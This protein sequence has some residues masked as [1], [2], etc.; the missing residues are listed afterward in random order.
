MASNGR[1]SQIGLQI[2]L[3]LVIIALAYFLY[4]SITD[5]WQEVREQERLTEETR[6]RMTQIRT[7]L[8]RY[9]GVNDRYTADLDSLVMFVKSDS[10]LRARPDSIFGIGFDADQLP[11]SPR[12]GNRFV[13]AVND[14]ARV[15]TYLLE[16]PDSDDFIGT[17]AG[18]VTRLN[19]SSWE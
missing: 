13:L 10:L 17:L 2:L 3:S 16:D 19:A 15:K 8:I 18:D 14:T 1:G 7:A 5:P 9:E 6:A 11:I 4:R 12:T